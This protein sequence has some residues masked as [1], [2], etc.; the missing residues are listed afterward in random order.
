[1]W[2]NISYFW[3]YLLRF[4]SEGALKV[5]KVTIE[6]FFLTLARKNQV[7]TSQKNALEVY[8]LHCTWTFFFLN[9]WTLNLSSKKTNFFLN[10]RGLASKLSKIVAMLILTLFWEVGLKPLNLKF[11]M[12]FWSENLVMQISGGQIQT[13]ISTSGQSHK[14]ILY[15]NRTVSQRGTI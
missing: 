11:F 12:S 9:F 4:R 3:G 6:T 8:D 2:K 1:M 10:L 7:F 15:T 13:P 14:K 5:L